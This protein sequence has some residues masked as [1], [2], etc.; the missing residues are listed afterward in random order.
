MKRIAAAAALILLTGVLAPAA[1]AATIKP[2]DRDGLNL[3]AGPGTQYAVV[4][5]LAQ[6]QSALVISR[7]GDWYK[8][9][10]SSGQE[11]WVAGWYSRVLLDDEERYAVVDTDLLNV[12]RI[13]NLQAAIVAQVVQGERVRLLEINPQ[14]WRVRLA[15]GIEGWVASQYMKEVPAGTKAS[16]SP[17][18]N[19]S[20]TP[21][22]GPAPGAGTPQPAPAAP[23]PAPAGTVPELVVPPPRTLA[24]LP[25][26]EVQVRSE[27]GVYAGPNSEARKVD[28]VR[29]GER[30]RLLDVSG[31]W[32]RAET[33]R[34]LRGWIHGSLVQVL[35]GR[36]QLSLTEMAWALE[37]LSAVPVTAPAAPAAETPFRTVRDADGLNLRLVP[38]MT[39]R[40]VA[41]LPQGEM[42][43]V[44]QKQGAWYRVK[45][46]AGLTGWVHGDYTL[47][48]GLP[49]TT[50]APVV[51]GDGFRVTMEQPFTGASRL[52]VQTPEG[53]AMGQPVLS[54]SVLVIP[55]PTGEPEERSI[56]LNLLG[57]KRATVAP[58]GLMLELEGQPA[59]QVEQSVPGKL[60]LMIRPVLQGITREMVDGK[61]VFRFKISGSTQP[62]AREAGENIIVEIPGAVLSG[63]VS[64]DGLR[65]VAHE[66]GVR[67][68]IPTYR[69]FS[70][71]RYDQGYY[72]VVYPPG[73]AGKVI[74][75]DPG[76]GGDDSGAVS[77]LLGVVE[78]ELNLQ[79][80]L[81]LRAAL[82]A[83]GA[84]VYMTR[85]T[86]RRAAPESYLT[87][88]E[89]EPRD[90]LDMQYRT[91]MANQ[92]KVDLF[93]SIHHN[94]GNAGLRGTET[95]YTSGSLNGERSKKA[96]A[97]IQEELVRALGTVN[98]G[99]KDDTF[100]VTRNTEAPAVLVEVAFVTDQ[101]DGSR[102]RES[103][104]QM[105][106]VE[107]MVRALERLF[108]ERPR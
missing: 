59:L 71:K 45:T 87:S 24:A 53:T 17:S 67:V 2:I 94:A 104:F 12:R 36:L 16:P 69:G 39:G 13:P 40:I 79:V 91:L 4:G 34:S 92:L 90:Q 89:G 95:F 19:P 9:R 107:S 63:P 55:F 27:T 93:V 86:D 14:W 21:S 10:L 75:L 100:Y 1:D 22:P 25:G 103:A 74:L 99:A 66:T 50:P 8:V 68:A 43:E 65:V 37:A 48:H 56:P 62:V 77:R 6:D 80:A 102:A 84:K 5:G 101:Q 82:E 57:V 105:A 11:G 60:S 72:L 76:H 58:A 35:D 42:L 3:R 32:V 26:K 54:G 20:P 97:L 70:M 61:A 33:P 47:P 38:L 44:L 7:E 85:V 96:A 15:S 41:V 29:P 64:L 30:L 98:R 78:K 31:G 23:P 106:A 49:A 73:L 88:A 51:K 83:R 52:M 28:T 18:P 108:A 81:R 46:Q